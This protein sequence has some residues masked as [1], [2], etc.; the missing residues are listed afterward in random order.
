MSYKKRQ[1]RGAHGKS[2]NATASR[3]NSFSKEDL[4]SLKRKDPPE[5][6]KDLSNEIKRFQNT[7]ESTDICQKDFQSIIFLLLKVSSGLSG[8]ED[9]RQRA[10]KILGEVF[11]D[12]CTT[13][14][15]TLK[16]YVTRANEK[17]LDSVCDFFQV[18]LEKL[19]DSS[20]RILPVDE[21]CAAIQLLAEG[22]LLDNED[23]LLPKAE[24]LLE[25]RNAMKDQHKVMIISSTCTAAKKP[26]DNSEYRLIQIL[27]K[28]E[29]ISTQ[30]PPYQLRPNIVE[31][32][33]DDWMHYYD[34]QFRLLREDFISP[35]RK[36]IGDY[37]MGRVGRD[38]R[39][40]KAY[41]KVYI[42]KPLFTRAGLCHKLWFDPAP[43]R[44]YQWE[45][46]KRL[47]FG[48]LL[49]LSPDHFHSKVLFATVSNSDPKD[50]SKGY[51]EVMFQGSTDLLAHIKLKR[52]FIMVESL[53][54][55][56][57]SRH[58]L[59]SLQIAEVGTMPFT[60]Y[61]I[62]NDC[63]EVHHPKY[64][65]NREVPSTYNIQ[66]IV[67]HYDSVPC[68]FT[69]VAITDASQWPTLDMTELDES[70]LKAMKMALSQE[71]SVIQ[72]P[73][74]TGKTYM[75]LKIVQ[76]LL[77]NRR[78]WN[79]RNTIRGGDVRSS[80][81]P[82]LVMCFTN[83]ALDQ[84]L[85]GILD[86]HEE[87]D[88]RLIRIGGRSKNEKIQ[89]CSL[90]NVKKKL[91]NV[92]N[93]EYSKMKNLSTQ[94]E[95]EGE[96]CS[97]QISSYNNEDPRCFVSFN[98]IKFVIEE[99]LYWS[100]IEPAETEEEERI[101]LELWLGLYTKEVREEYIPIPAEPPTAMA[102]DPSSSSDEDSNYEDDSSSEM[103]AQVDDN[104][105]AATFDETIDVTG[106]ASIEKDARMIDGVTEMF[107]EMKFESSDLPLARKK[108]GQSNYNIRRTFKI[109]E[110]RDAYWVKKHIMRGS[111]MLEREVE[112]IVNVYAL[113][114]QERYKL[115]M[116]WHSKYRAHLMQELEEGCKVFNEK[117]EDANR[118]RK[119]ADR[120][121][122]D[123]A[124]VIGM[125][126]TGA[127]KYQ[128]VLHLVKPK[129]V[130]V[131]EAAEVLESHIVSALNAG[132]QH[133]ILIGDHK[134]LRPNPNEYDLI[135]KYKLDISLFERLVKN[136]FP[137][138][139]LQIQHRMRPEIADLVRGHIYDVLH[140][141]DSV[142][143]YPKVKGV[144]SNLFFIQHNEAEK[145][146]DLSH[147]NE[148]EAAYLAAL[149]KFLL[150]QGYSASQIT[151]LVTYS[152]QLRL[153][154]KCMPKSDFEGIRVSTVDNFQGE[155][156]DII[157]L[158]LVRSNERG[159]IGFLK[160]ENRVCVALSRAK[161]GFYCIGNFEMLRRGSD[162]WQNIISDVE[163][164]GKVGESL[165]IHCNNH[166][167]FQNRA[168]YPGDFAKYFPI[169]GCHL[170]CEYRLKCGHVCTLT[171]H[172]FDPEHEKYMCKKQVNDSCPEGHAVVRLCHEDLKCAE[173]VM[174]ILPRC[175][176]TEQMHCYQD[177]DKIHCM[178]M[179]TKSIP[180]CRHSQE[181]LCSQDP[182]RVSCQHLCEQA[183]P[184]GHECQ[185][186]CHVYPQCPPCKVTSKVQLP[187]C[188]HTKTKYCHQDIDEVKC[189]SACEKKCKSGHPCK[190][191]C[192]Q[193]CNPCS[194]LVHKS[195]PCG[196]T[197]NVKCSENSIAICK[198][199]CPKNLSCGHTCPSLCGKVCRDE[200]CPESIEITLPK[201]KHKSMLPC[202]KKGDHLYKY[203]VK[204][205]KPCQKSLSC[206]HRC[207]GTCG[208]PCIEKC[209]VGGIHRTCTQ[210]HK[211]IRKCFETFDVNPCNK[212][213]K[214]KLECRHPCQ[215]KCSESCSKECNF[216][217]IKIYPCS[218]QHMLSCS[219]SIEQHP[220]DIICQAPLACGHTCRG[221]CSDCRSTRIH[222]PCEFSAT[223]PHFFCGEKTVMKC[224]GLKD[225]HKKIG[226]PILKV[227]HCKHIK[228]PYE[229]GEK[230]FK[231]SEPCEW[232][233]PH[234]ACSKLCHELCNRLPCD[235]RCPRF[236]VCGHQCVGL[237]GEPCIETCPTCDP[238]NF[239]SLLIM[240]ETY[241]AEQVYTQLPCGHLS[242][243]L[244]MDRLVRRPSSDVIPVQCPQCFSLLS[245][246]YRYG[247]PVKEAL[248]CIEAVKAKMTASIVKSNL[249]SE[250][251]DQLHRIFSE[252][253]F[254]I[255]M[256]NFK[257]RL[258]RPNEV[259]SKE[260][261]FIYFLLATVSKLAS[262]T[263]ETVS[264]NIYQQKLVSMTKENKLSYQVI[265]DLLSELYRL[266]FQARLNSCQ[267]YHSS[268]S[269][270]IKKE[271]TFLRG[272]D[273]PLCRMSRQKFT[274]HSRILDI[275]STGR[276]SMFKSTNEFIEDVYRFQPLIFNGCWQK[277]CSDH[278]YCIPV[279]K[280]GSIKMHCPE[281]PGM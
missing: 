6:I 237:C 240:S 68:S 258:S 137:H 58:I 135:V 89:E 108:E 171:C 229:C 280:P 90:Y 105:A 250:E 138:V 218:H 74:G 162:T 275:I 245:C 246:S 262:S 65:N 26:W 200:T 217:V 32:K 111:E 113:H 30:K 64:L 238:D 269:E 22:G 126:T 228:V 2:T 107:E 186:L 97:R 230:V 252:M 164:K 142:E 17:N 188:G 44:T 114:L 207:T 42:L 95:A 55:F 209:E 151:V 183:C 191:E 63:S 202:H 36:G 213:C 118:A 96:K 84:F 43:F 242:T 196:H 155:E 243:I 212:Q 23:N 10:L 18:L 1:S 168:K 265:Q 195:F 115:Y 101:A 66:F 233:C 232:S 21:L 82:I 159:V 144:G 278:Y 34:I 122:L 93:A 20:W 106:E 251:K 215:N 260:D 75:G 76:A 132:T 98:A 187:L 193:D 277:C 73:P 46:S 281:C 80:R 274:R 208:E 120:Y 248:F 175:G 109:V 158:S 86:T 224:V 234:Q 12:R 279:C 257:Y 163:T 99:H 173:R 53:A 239:S 180:S 261:G 25:Q 266:Y 81:S 190:L 204:C 3:L 128:H 189:H 69:K 197:A 192:H 221:K 123:A 165:I 271:Q 231:C 177:P 148:H 130:I 140:D 211:H 270:L 276:K 150:Q 161:H 125:T 72:G 139:T 226:Q 27:P 154:K 222:K 29:E 198:M 15:S 220:C 16:Q 152:G 184:E 49:C 52:E 8:D 103:E 110:N 264:L 268:A 172:S 104:Q 214:K 219:T 267:Q 236:L 201:C 78:I 178:T 133:L 31:G 56:E 127:A 194:V 167:Q 199:P 170:P 70:Q 57:A 83:H 124:D 249:S 11:S 117:C 77:K 143:N 272:H 47:I 51:F 88:L 156:N 91:Q 50:L 28:W 145:A 121:P 254:S 241:S 33:Y 169:G 112:K 41:H 203:R 87:E 185:L 244:D 181:M 45:H 176:H 206:G 9:M 61:L 5:I 182:G 263:T 227:L 210:G 60:K 205:T 19:P 7:L 48:S 100:L 134:Q 166:P 62:N 24:Q 4:A 256:S 179:C 13:F 223:Q 174:R 129:I 59:R 94:A 79:R 160:A 92:P 147:S 146:N 141:H 54:Y 149:C 247:N 216:Q 225:C 259:V 67:K 235:N 116:Y 119:N 153:V 37:L 157:L 253:P 131:E 102:S 255:A 39:N 35:L 85:E 40:V 14:Q 273:D 136:D 38:L 71:I